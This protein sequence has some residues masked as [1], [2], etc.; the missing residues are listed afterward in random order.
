M[1]DFG[2]EAMVLVQQRRLW[3][4]GIN[5]DQLGSRRASLTL[6]GLRLQ[7]SFQ[8]ELRVPGLLLRRSMYF[9]GIS[10]CRNPS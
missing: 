6:Q 4:L 1:V 10:E 3:S 2:D 5:L 7:G 9:K 8:K